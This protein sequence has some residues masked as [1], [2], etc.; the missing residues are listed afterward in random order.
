VGS[1]VR[2]FAFYGGL[3]DIV[4]PDNLKSAVSKACRYDPDINPTYQQMAEHCRSGV[5]VVERWIMM[6]LR[7][8]TFYMLVGTPLTSNTWPRRIASIRSGGRN[9]FW[10]GRNAFWIGRN[11]LAQT[12]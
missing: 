10:I 5:Q 12:P 8:L 7:K 11:A 6:R 1:H 4:V 3:P 9:A 2:A